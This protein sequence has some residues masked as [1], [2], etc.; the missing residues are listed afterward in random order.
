MFADFPRES[1]ELEVHKH[2]DLT[3]DHEGWADSYRSDSKSRRYRRQWCGPMTS[4]II[5]ITRS[6][7]AAQLTRRAIQEIVSDNELGL[8][9]ALYINI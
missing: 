3:V 4:I 2:F 5:S 8:Y 9:Y 7:I 1:P 6:G